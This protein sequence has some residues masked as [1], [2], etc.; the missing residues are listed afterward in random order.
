MLVDIHASL[1]H[2]QPEWRQVTF[3]GQLH[4]I[5]LIQLDGPRPQLKL[6]AESTTI[7]MAA[8]RNCKT[9][10]NIGIDGLDF[11]FYSDTGSM[12]VIDITS[13]QALVGR[14]RDENLWAIVDR[15]GSLA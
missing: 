15:S 5:Y 4:H 6:A 14:V 7:I 12:H 13:I 8:I 11:H 1:R 10:D 9:I 3:Y 2:V